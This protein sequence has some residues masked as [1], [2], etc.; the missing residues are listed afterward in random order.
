MCLHV[1][2]YLTKHLSINLYMYKPIT[3]L[4]LLGANWE[5]IYS[6]VVFSLSILMTTEVIFETK[7]FVN[8]SVRRS[9]A[10]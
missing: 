10:W 6:V 9:F 2:I 8:T 3:R 5:K 7:S 4:C 1:C